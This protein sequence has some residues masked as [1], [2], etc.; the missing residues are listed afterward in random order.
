MKIFPVIMC[1]GAGTR[2][3]PASRPDRPKQF[4]SL[5]G[6]ESLF[7]DTVRRVAPL[8]LGGGAL[9]VVCGTEHRDSVAGQLSTINLSATI[10]LEPEARD[11]APAMAAAAAWIA[12]QDPEGLAVYVASDHY[13]PDGEAFRAAVLEAAAAA[14]VSNRILTLGVR[15]TDP[16][17]AYGYIRPRGPGLSPIAEFVEKPTPEMASIYLNSGYLWN[18]GNFVVRASGLLDELDRHAPAVSG[19][20][21]AAVGAAEGVGEL[22]LGSAFRDAPRISIDY[23]LME[24]TTAAWVL[25]VSFEWSDLGA[26]DAVAAIGAVVREQTIHEG[27]DQCYVRAPAGMMVATVG[28]SNIAVIVEPDAILVCNMS[29]SQNVK[30]VVER[31]RIEAPR[32][33][34]RRPGGVEVQS[35]VAD[36][37]AWLNLRALPLWSSIGLDDAG[38]FAESLDGDGADP[39]TFQRSR[40]PA[41]QL[42]V[43]ARAGRIGWPGRWRSVLE[44]GIDRYW[45]DFARPD[46]LVRAL[47]SRT[48][49]PL[50]DDAYLYDQAFALLALASVAEAGVQ[51]DNC[52]LRAKALVLGL[53]SRRLAS[54]GWRE[55][56]DRPFQ[57]NAHMHLL[58]ACQAWEALDPDGPWSAMVDE[59]VALAMERFIDR[60]S[61][62]LHEFFTDDWTAP[63]T[64]ESAL[65]EP[66]HQFEWAWLLTRHSIRRGDEAA[67]A[68]ARRLY[69]CGMR[70]VMDDPAVACD[71]L[72]ADLSYR[73][74]RARLWP[75]TEW[76]KAALILDR[77]GGDAA[78]Y[79]GDTVRA[80]S[81]VARYL[82]ADGR[83]RDKLSPDGTFVEEPAPASSMYHLMAAMEQLLAV[84]KRD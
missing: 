46:G 72:N 2:L 16:S 9:V 17:S 66:G 13:L 67:L 37:S 51:G 33:L 30:A 63:P 53:E 65:V 34:S 45:V 32:F 83:W 80:R 74:R 47:V 42:Y 35:D 14:Q 76:L 79:A 4:L 58:E 1:G 82:L 12:E 48:G 23:A 49:E 70:G 61:G 71:E 69:G 22:R 5:A 39:S 27:G 59:I 3:W 43:F 81:A 40:V 21:R 55:V 54:G 26:W 78:D 7:Q 84:D 28:L 75:Q 68:A 64:G 38:R 31:L 11:S 6:P 73:S 19:A 77:A 44:L 15:P 57:A 56:G 24:K 29:A 52:A 62:A 25:P 50:D 8:T 18:S 41:R 20:A 10:L 36:L 60:T